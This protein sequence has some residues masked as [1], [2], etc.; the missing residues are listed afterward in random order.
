[1]YSV[2]FVIIFSAWQGVRWPESTCHKN[3][4]NS[5]IIKKLVLMICNLRSASSILRNISAVT[6]LKS[7]HIQLHLITRYFPR[8]KISKS[9]FP[10]QSVWPGS[11]EYKRKK[12]SP[13]GCCSTTRLYFKSSKE[14]NP[15]LVIKL[16]S[17]PP[18]PLSIQNFHE[19][20]AKFERGWWCKG[21]TK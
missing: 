21:M 3:K 1:M 12:L 13:D 4:P 11:V 5:E 16:A 19:S 10:G 8:L 14:A 7:F 17:G 9:W 6:F 2:L 15:R 20:Q 18:Y